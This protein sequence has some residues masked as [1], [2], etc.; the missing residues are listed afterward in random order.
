M[1]FNTLVTETVEILTYPLRVDNVTCTCTRRPG[2]ALWG[3]PH[4]LQQVLINLLTN[5]QQGAPR[6]PGAREVTSPHS[7]TLHSTASRSR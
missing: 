6:R 2:A 1:A 5:A 4:Q 7:T 3:D